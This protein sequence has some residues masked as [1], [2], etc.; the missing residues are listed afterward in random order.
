[1]SIIRQKTSDLK[2]TE[3]PFIIKNEN[4]DVRKIN[5]IK[6]YYEKNLC[7]SFFYICNYSNISMYIF[8]L[9]IYKITILRLSV[10]DEITIAST[11]LIEHDYFDKKHLRNIFIYESN[12]GKKTFR[13]LLEKTS[14][15]ILM[16]NQNLSLNLNNELEDNKLM[17]R[18]TLLFKDVTNLNGAER[19]NYDILF[20]FEKENDEF[21]LSVEYNESII[22]E[23][24][25]I[26]FKA[27]FD[28]ILYQTIKDIE[29]GVDNEI[30]KYSI[31]S[32]QE[33]AELR[34]TDKAL[35]LLTI[36]SI[37]ADF[38]RIVDEKPLSYALYYN[39]KYITYKELDI[40][41]NQLA[42]LLIE[43]RVSQNDIIGVMMDSSFEFI[44]SIL[45]VMKAGC[46]YLP[47]NCSNPKKRIVSMLEECNVKILITMLDYINSFPYIDLI[48]YDI[49]E[50]SF[51]V[52][53]PREQICDLDDIQI[54]DRSFI[55]YDKYSS[56]IS[57]AM[58]KYSISIQFSRGC[59]FKC[60]YCFKI[61]KDKYIVRS[62]EN[63]FEEIKLYYNMGFKRFG[64]VD[65]LPNFDIEE[66]AKLYQM[67]IDNDMDV[68]LHF[69]N[70]IRGDIL[71]PQYIDLMI[72][73]GTVNI[74]LALETTSKRLQKLICKNLNLERLK[75][76]I[77]YIAENY[78]HVILQTQIL[79]GIPTETEEEARES[80]EFLKTI[81]WIHFPY[82]HVLK[83]YPNTEMAKIAMNNGVLAEDIETSSRLGYHELPTTL[84]FSHSFTKQLQ[85]TFLNEYFL[86]K[87]RL[88]SVLPHQMKILT[89]DELIQVY[90]GYLPAAIHTFED[91][92]KEL[93]LTRDE[94]NKSEFLPNDFGKVDNINEKMKK[95]FG[96]KIYKANALKIL[97]LDVSLF[98]SD[99]VNNQY[100]VSE[101]PLG[102]MYLA[103]NIYRKFG[104]KVKI[105]IAK[106]RIDYDSFNELCDLIDNFKPD[107]IGIRS[108]NYYENFF[109]TTVSAIR[110]WGFSGPL[111]AGGPY[112]TT[113]YTKLLK[114]KRVD[115]AI[116]GEGEET[117]NDI[118]ELIINSNNKL[119]NIAALSMIPGLAFID[120]DKKEKSE[121]YGVEIFSVDLYQDILSKYP[122]NKPPISISNK[123]LAYIIYTSGSTGKPKGVK[124]HHDNLANQIEGFISKISLERNLNYILLADISFDVSVMHIFLSLTTGGI[125]HLISDSDKKTPHKLWSYVK[126][127][128]IDI[129]N[130]TPT[131]IDVLLDDTK[132]LGDYII[133]YLFIGGESFPTNTYKKIK[134][135]LNAEQIYNI[136]GP[137]ETTIN[138]TAYKC[139][140]SD[141]AVIMPI[142]K[143]FP[144]YYVYVLDNDMNLLPKGYIGQLFIS[145]S[146]VSSGYINDKL[147][148][149]QKF[150]QDPYINNAIM[151]S[152]GDMVQWRND[153]NLLFLGRNDNQVKIRG[154]R[155]ELGQIENQIYQYP[156]I[157]QAVVAVNQNENN[158]K[159]LCA[160]YSTNTEIDSGH[161][162]LFLS[163]RLPDYMIP[164][165]FIQLEVLPIS[166]NGK[167]NYQDLPLPQDNQDKQ[168]LTSPSNKLEQFMVDIWKKVLNIENVGIEQ[169]FF[170]I[171]GHSLRAVMLEVELKKNNIDV[172]YIDIYNYKT[173]K[174]YVS[175]LL[176]SGK[177]YS[178]D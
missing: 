39:D 104:N 120:S 90:D 23:N 98:F 117:I 21:S 41:S 115:I 82:I 126:Y 94:L 119:P 74:D 85:L 5:R 91:L 174:S 136:Y 31:L 159:T 68:Q 17:E 116:I 16:S 161:L 60:A 153:G 53:K 162:K 36:K 164:S 79:H 55:N 107:V 25:I 171:G 130:C 56:S 178:F 96:L 24:I 29:N 70:G 66:S 103:T 76:N 173:I 18:F 99:S 152:S 35:S 158:E 81:K 169:D 28:M 112:S 143:P 59:A 156:S 44:I 51:V 145:G 114:D 101:P 146:G 11:D 95:H 166:I 92:L 93:G 13:Q 135:N 127:K 106:S 129:V 73:A 160:Y 47:I 97:F 176:S 20:I 86:S 27:R 8:L 148:T 109:H 102:L 167:I 15:D 83:I 147:L 105:K 19:L 172:N 151:Y 52:T 57:Q 58:V 140:E 33:E 142:G 170:E 128:K 118:I 50:S 64:F 88:L 139:E 26:D 132:P 12:N 4:N 78:P 100:D 46:A 165:F 2:I 89:E 113:S 40:K 111:L 131:F 177:E 30:N 138:T 38:E 42:H 150:I 133:K 110:Q 75:E 108:L 155:I 77:N 61:W 6:T 84:P 122:I 137:T 69:P 175:Y 3:F 121:N 80:L 65:D 149:S 7:S 48:S 22:E 144:N 37:V 62:A 1:M 72:K 87:E 43:K 124:I 10:N 71:T 14:D 32:K 123:D 45:G 134:R 49:K 163:S 168:E 157:D 125:L 67:I 54:P 34:P 63:M 154:F 141:C 9:T